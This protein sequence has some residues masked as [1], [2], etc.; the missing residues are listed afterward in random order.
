[1]SRNKNITIRFTEK[2]FEIID[3]NAQTNNISKSEF[4]R[5]LLFTYYNLVKKN[6]YKNLDIERKL[7]ELKMSLETLKLSLNKTIETSLSKIDQNL[8]ELESQILLRIMKK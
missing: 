3:K 2:E 7:E 4:I 6:T 1:M 5:M 8:S